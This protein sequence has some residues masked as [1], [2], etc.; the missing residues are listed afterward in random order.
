MPVSSYIF[1]KNLLKSRNNYRIQRIFDY[2]LRIITFGYISNK[3]KLEEAKFEYI[4]RL[5]DYFRYQDIEIKSEIIEKST[6]IDSLNNI[7]LG[8]ETK[9]FI[10]VIGREDYGNDWGLIR[11]AILLRDNY[12]CQESDG[13]CNGVLQVHHI[14]PL[15]KGGTNQPINLITLC[16]YHHSLKHEHMKNKL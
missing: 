11:D 16:F 2:S 15:S 8:K 13:Y 1:H 5:S 9:S 10:N 12:Q 6:N 7:R 14:V 3:R 4:T